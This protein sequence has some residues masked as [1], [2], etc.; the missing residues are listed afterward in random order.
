MKLTPKSIVR[1]LAIATLPIASSAAWVQGATTPEIAVPAGQTDIVKMSAKRGGRLVVA[2][3]HLPPPTPGARAAEPALTV[4]VAPVAQSVLHPRIIVTGNVVAWREMPIS[5]EATDLAVTEIAADE[6][7]TVD[8]G[9]LL[10]HLSSSILVAQVTQQE[11]VIAELE[12][13]LASAKSDVRR[14][15]SLTSG[16][17]SA[18]TTEQRETLVT[19]TAAKL[20]AARA[21]LDEIK[22]RLK[23]T[24]IRAPSAGIV[25]MRSVTLGQVVQTGTEMFRIIQDGRIEVNALVPEADLFSVQVGQSVRVIGPTGQTQQGAVR[26]IVPVVDGKTRLGTARVALPRDTSLKPGMFTRVEITTDRTAAL[27]VPLKAVVWQQAKPAVFKVAD[28][29]IAQL[30]EVSLG[31]KTSDAIEVTAGLDVGD[32]VVVAGAGLLKDGDVVRVE[33]ASAQGKASQ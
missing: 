27:T 8:K 10:A 25:A 3:A 1:G 17:I 5:T 26:L 28:A 22:T 6:G 31:R 4:I 7:D 11:A 13:T 21:V 29:G 9:Q 14:A 20:S 23:Q 30:T 2:Q 19:T 32:H 24:E 16:V 33:M 12:A 18:Q 15:R